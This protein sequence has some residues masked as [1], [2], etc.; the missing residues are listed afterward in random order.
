MSLWL[1]G[2]KEWSSGGG[3]SMIGKLGKI[4]NRRTDGGG[5]EEEG[6]RGMRGER[7][8]RGKL[9]FGSRAAAFLLLD[10]LGGGAWRISDLRGY[11]L[12]TDMARE[13]KS[14]GNPAPSDFF[15]F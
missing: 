6:G 15:L 9:G 13:R 4:G 14:G 7:E 5:D 10:R 1:G 2:V 12:S 8:G 3:V 11:L